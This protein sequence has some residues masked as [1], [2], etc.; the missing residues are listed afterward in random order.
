MFDR[1]LFKTVNKGLNLRLFWEVG[2]FCIWYNVMLKTDYNKEIS[3]KMAVLC[4]DSD[5][6]HDDNTYIQTYSN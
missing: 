1:R 4:M 2:G 5:T 3:C 6:A